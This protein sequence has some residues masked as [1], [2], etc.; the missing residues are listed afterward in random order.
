MTR[1]YLFRKLFLMRKVLSIDIMR[2]F[3]RER[4]GKC[5]SNRYLNSHTPLEWE[6]HE[7]HRWFARPANVY[8]SGTW[9]PICSAGQAGRKRRHTIEDM[10][11]IA[12]A[13][14]GKCVSNEYN[15][16]NIKLEWECKD[17]HRWWNTPAHI[18]S[19][20]WCPTCLGRL[21][22]TLPL[23]E[24]TRTNLYKLADMARRKGGILLSQRYTNNKTLLRWR[25]NN[26]H[27]WEASASTIRQ[28]RWCHVCAGWIKGTIEGMRELAKNRGGQCIS[29]TYISSG[30]K[31]TWQCSVGHEWRTT[32]NRVQQGSWCPEC[33]SGLGERI[34]RAYFEQLF[35]HNFPK[36]RPDWLEGMELDG[37]CAKLK[38]AFEHQG[39]Y[40][41]GKDKRFDEESV[42]D[43]Q[44]R[45]RV[46][47]RLCEANAISLIE[48]P[49]IPSLLPI[50]DIKAY[51]R[52]SC[53]K[54][55][56]PL[57]KMYDKTQVD[58][59]EAYSPDKLEALRSLAAPFEGE[60]VSESY[61]GSKHKYIWK[62]SAGHLFESLPANVSKGQW[63]PE[64]AG[65]KRLEIGALHELANSRGGMLIA[66]KYTRNS[67]KLEWQCACG[68]IWTA[69]VRDIRR[70]HWCPVCGIEQRSESQRLGIEEMKQM[71]ASK[72]GAC[73]SSSYANKESKLEW[74]C[75]RGHTWM[76]TPGKI[77]QGRWCPTCAIEKRAKKRR[78]TID[79][80]RSIASMYQGECLS[81]E[82]FNARTKLEWR[83]RLGH[84]WEA[85]PDNVK[86]GGWCPI[87]RK[88][89]PSEKFDG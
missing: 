58:L 52:I 70:G 44:N 17:K 82:Y 87:C 80:M 2:E 29:E 4:N 31:L 32:P 85:T 71:A 9:C 28:G 50:S 30:K 23:A 53:M 34:A 54:L 63:C 62:C 60:L 13:R 76:A 57:P 20:Q 11:E 73:L 10:H 47:K 84:T 67:D 78:L 26:G 16:A 51:V 86:R 27:E 38:L 15:G 77:R 33:S 69:R 55:G 12:R 72:H 49:E 75:V 3:A 21:P 81:N 24:A 37:F 56:V 43:V 8:Y 22:S 18:K 5:L 7:G 45:D 64:C 42:A 66:T 36:C 46:K 79:A 19:G 61:L 14:G 89:S 59:I 6:C 88:L 65:N 40:H 35:R 83:C 74:R 41:Y 1:L 48:V 68:N 39:L 25:C